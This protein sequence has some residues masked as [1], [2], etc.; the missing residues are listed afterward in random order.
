MSAFAEKLK[1]LNELKKKF[2][3]GEECVNFVLE[4]RLAELFSFLPSYE[5][6]DGS[7]NGI[8]DSTL[9][10]LLKISIN[11]FYGTVV[12]QDRKICI[13]ELKKVNGYNILT[14]LYKTYFTEKFKDYVAIILGRFHDGIPL[15]IEC[16]S[17]IPGLK[18]IISRNAPKDT[19]KSIYYVN[20]ALVSLTSIANFYENKK[21]LIFHDVQMVVL[22]LLTS[23]NANVAVHSLTLLSNFCSVGSLEVRNK[24]IN[25]G[26][27]Q[28]FLPL[29]HYF[30]K[31]QPL[32]PATGN[33]VIPVGTTVNNV[34][35][36]IGMLISGNEVGIDKFLRAGL[37]P[38]FC[39]LLRDPPTDPPATVSP[40]DFERIACNMLNTFVVSAAQKLEQT[41]FLL[42]FPHVLS[43]V[44]KAIHGNSTPE[45][46]AP[47]VFA[48]IKVLYTIAYKGADA[49]AQSATNIFKEVVDGL[50]VVSL[51][52]S[53][54]K[55]ISSIPSNTLTNSQIDAIRQSALAVALFL[56]GTSPPLAQYD[57]VIQ[58]LKTLKELPVQTGVGAVVNVK[59]NEYRE[60][61]KIALEGLNVPDDE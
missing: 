51:L 14:L 11:C 3:S 53:V 20:L 28:H 19:A 1:K 8:I 60:G 55:Y 35:A 61:A 59:E 56:K 47:L 22:P 58:V 49:S 36:L 2:L 9:E 54:F 57:D 7:D 33:S 30:S 45:A 40:E 44:V 46:D 26:I 41:N 50:E 43:H 16:Q 23:N 32:N 12:E 13:E 39:I 18:G 37:I 29:L 52:Y 25:G 31:K 27:F 15:P 17:I 4:G 10:S 42:T 24:I 48:A 21:L 34:C 38:L 6:K 5:T